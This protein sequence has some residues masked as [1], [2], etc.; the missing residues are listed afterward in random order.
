MPASSRELKLDPAASL[1]YKLLCIAKRQ[2][3]QC[4]MRRQRQNCKVHNQTE[5]RYNLL[6]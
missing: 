2:F 4:P 5:P 1:L 6:R 3:L